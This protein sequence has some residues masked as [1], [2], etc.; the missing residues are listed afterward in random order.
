MESDIPSVSAVRAALSNLSMRQLDELARLS[1][2][3]MT[4]IYKIKL[5][6]TENPGIETVRKFAPHISTAAQVDAPKAA[7]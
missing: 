3:P 5:G 6:E 4:T 7:A 2:V 1:G